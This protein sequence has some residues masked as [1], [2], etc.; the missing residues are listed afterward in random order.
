MITASKIVLFLDFPEF[1]I[2]LS[3]PLDA[4]AFEFRFLSMFPSHKD[5]SESN[6]VDLFLSPIAHH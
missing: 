3:I 5:F 2:R 4:Q 1:I 6:Q